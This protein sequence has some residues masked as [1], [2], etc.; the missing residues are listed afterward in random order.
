MEREGKLNYS[1]LI[2]M[3]RALE[4]NQTTANFVFSIRDIT[5]NE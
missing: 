1:L 2:D 4:L 3:L 5:E